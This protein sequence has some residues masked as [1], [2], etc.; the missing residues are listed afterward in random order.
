[1][2]A[3]E[4]CRDGAC[5]SAGVAGMADAV[6]FHGSRRAH[7][8][9]PCTC[10]AVIDGNQRQDDAALLRPFAARQVGADAPRTDTAARGA[11]S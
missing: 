8:T 3:T 6:E 11:R 2:T 5:D 4:A 10:D 1:M 7:R 9:T